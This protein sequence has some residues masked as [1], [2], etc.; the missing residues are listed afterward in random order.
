MYISAFLDATLRGRSEYI[1]MFRNH[2][3]AAAWL[4][5]TVYFSRFDES[6]FRVVADFDE[7]IDVTK[8]S[9]PGGSLRSEGLSV[10]RQQEL[11]GRGDWP[12]RDHAVVLGWNV[13]TRRQRPVL[14]DH[15]ARRSAVGLATG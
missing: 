2:R 14:R 15:P 4:P 10:W 12:F 11:K 9:V 3:R 6:G 8:A 5:D 7:S 13:L 1:P